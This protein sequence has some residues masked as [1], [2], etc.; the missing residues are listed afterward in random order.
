MT[1]IV[2]ILVRCTLIVIGYA[3]AALAAGAVLGIAVIGV[4]S[5]DLA[6]ARP[7]FLFTLGMTSVMIGYWAFLP[8]MAIIL[9]GEVLRKRDWL[10]YAIGGGMGGLAM[11]A[12]REGWAGDIEFALAVVAS[13]IAG[14]WAYWLIAGRSAALWQPTSRPPSGS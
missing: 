6:E 11:L 10:F 3:A 7:A 13:G 9:L 5:G 2:E 1:N 8:A 12:W 4:H 14:G